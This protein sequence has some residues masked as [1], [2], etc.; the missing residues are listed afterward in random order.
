MISGI[1]LRPVK[2]NLVGVQSKNRQ[3]TQMSEAFFESIWQAAD[4]KIIFYLRLM[5]AGITG[6][7]GK[8]YAIF[9]LR[10]IFYNVFK[11]TNCYIYHGIFFEHISKNS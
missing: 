10:E 11:G 8:V 2:I 3:T 4:Q 9:I 5:D 7:R 6:T 1:E